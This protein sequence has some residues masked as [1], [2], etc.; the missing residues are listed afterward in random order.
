MSV[1]GGQDALRAATHKE[2][3]GRGLRDREAWLKEQPL[4]GLT[5][6]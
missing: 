2:L 5:T 6:V 3:I 4:A 1:S